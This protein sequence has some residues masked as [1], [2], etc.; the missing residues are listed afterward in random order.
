MARR[1]DVRQS[2][3]ECTGSVD[4]LGGPLLLFI[5]VWRPS[6]MQELKEPKESRG[7]L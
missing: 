7:L 6:R 4:E 2:S 3:A 5:L 1:I